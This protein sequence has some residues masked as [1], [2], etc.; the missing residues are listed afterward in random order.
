MG[1]WLIGLEKQ[2]DEFSHCG[3]LRLVVFFVPL[4]GLVNEDGF[5]ERCFKRLLKTVLRLQTAEPR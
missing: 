4:R 1:F 2:K 3:K 5:E